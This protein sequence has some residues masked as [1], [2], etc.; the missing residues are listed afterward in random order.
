MCCSGHARMAAHGMLGHAR[1]Q[2]Q[3]VTLRCCS[4]PLSRGVP[5]MLMKCVNLQLVLGTCGDC[6]VGEGA[7][8]C[9]S[10]DLPGLCRTTSLM[11]WCK[12]W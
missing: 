3:K 6:A 5:G 11:N 12:G 9:V 4:G 10:K 8:I 7:G 2:Q 1:M